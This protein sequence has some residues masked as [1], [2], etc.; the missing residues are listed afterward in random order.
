MPQIVRSFISPEEIDP[1]RTVEYS[2]LAMI[3]STLNR[4]ETLQFL[5]FLNLL[6]SSATIE[7][8]FTNNL[9]PVRD[10]Q[11]WLIREV[12]SAT[13]LA[14]LQAKFGAASLLD[15]PFLH[16]TQLLFVTRL[17]AT[18]GRVDGGNMLVTRDDFDAIGD[19]L[20]LTNGLFRVDEPAAKGST[21]LWLA[22]QMGPMHE[23]ENPPD[24]E[25]SW[26]RIHELFTRRLPAAAAD[27]TELER[28]ERVA[29][30][31]TGFNLEAWLDLSFL[32]FSFWFAVTFKD[33]MKDRSRGYLNPDTPHETVSR[34][35]L[36][37]ALASLSTPFAELPA[38]LRIDQ[39]SRATLFDLTPF[40]ASPLWAMP[41]GTALC[42]DVGLLIERLGGHA[43]WSVMNALD[44]P[45]RRRQFTGTWG[46]AFETYCLDRLAVV[47]RAKKWTF[48]R[49]PTDATNEEL[50]DAVAIRD[51]TAIVMECK[52]TF[53]RSA[54]KY[55]GEPCRF[56][57]GLSQKFGRVR[58]GGLYQ[59]RRGIADVWVNRTA[60]S[61]LS[62]LQAAKH[63]FPI[64]IVQDPIISCGPVM[65]VL[66]DRFQRSMRVP[67]HAGPKVWPLTVVTA[68]ALDRLSAVIEVT[69]ERLDSILKTF[70]RT[71]PSRM[72]SLDEFMS[73][74]G[75]RFNMKEVRTIINARFRAVSEAAM[76][77]FRSGEYGGAPTTEA[78]PPEPTL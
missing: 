2:E 17:V 33:L 66:S 43:F 12:I 71:H 32:L 70:H 40:R 64:L 14:R 39:F 38:R 28:L 31:T 30:F 47:F 24:I 20:F 11:T 77:R 54:D 4:D 76:Q 13:L 60:K 67:I 16:R 69:G 59:L 41:N 55:S 52:G 53:I 21:A 46:T 29:L 26:P 68:D 73:S 62:G 9:D 37:R 22:T 6:L 18:H 44:T 49:N 35:M 45:E 27:P 57:R 8:D 15:R 1:G 7:T 75:Q 61:S 74:N 36:T 3:A 72:I 5:G 65:R 51:D 63:V 78:S 19:L 58:H 42:I 10:V 50:W 56:F 23:T 48:V 25:L 34:E